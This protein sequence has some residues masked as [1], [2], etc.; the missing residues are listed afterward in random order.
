MLTSLAHGAAKVWNSGAGVCPLSSAGRTSGV[1]SAVLSS[2]RGGPARTES[3]GST[4]NFGDSDSGV[5][6]LASRRPDVLWRAHSSLLR[7]APLLTTSADHTAKIGA[8]ALETA[9]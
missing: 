8:L 4:A 2:G 9:G 5:R 7:R 6:L 3:D 1:G